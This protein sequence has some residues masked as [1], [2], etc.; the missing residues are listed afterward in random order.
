MKVGSEERRSTTKIIKRLG[1]NIVA[2]KLSTIGISKSSEEMEF[3]GQTV[4]YIQQLKIVPVKLQLCCVAK[5]S[6]HI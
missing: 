2:A 6:W 3:W 5:I 4:I 1:V